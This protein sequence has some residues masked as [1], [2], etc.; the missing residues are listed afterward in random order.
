MN[1]FEFGMYFQQEYSK[2]NNSNKNYT[3]DIVLTQIVIHS[4]APNNSSNDYCPQYSTQYFPP[5]TRGLD[6][7]QLFF[8]SI[9]FPTSFP[10]RFYIHLG[11]ICKLIK[12]LLGHFLEAGLEGVDVLG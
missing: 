1:E 8:G 11:F 2:R 5:S 3:D 4:D 6:G 10:I 7:R 9:D 12:G